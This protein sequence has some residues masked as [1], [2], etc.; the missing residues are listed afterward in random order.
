VTSVAPLKL[1]IGERLTIK[2]SGFLP[3]KSRN[4][5][6]FKATGG[7]AVFAKALSA[8]KTKLVVTVPPKLAPF[9]KVNAGQA[10]ATRFQLRVLAKKLSRSYTSASA[11]PMIAP[12]TDAV[13]ATA[14]TPAPAPAVAAVVPA[15]AATTPPPAPNCDGDS[16]P[17]SVDADDDN[18]LLPDTL[19]RQIGTGVCDA[20][21][22][23]DSMGDGWEYQS[24]SDF[25]R[26]SCPAAGYPTACPGAKPY[27]VKQPYTNPLYADANE[28]Y[29]G[30]YLPAGLE[31][32]MWKAH[33]PNTLT[34]MWYSDGL[35][36]SQD[37]NPNDTCVG[38]EEKAGGHVDRYPV[39]LVAYPTVI[40]EANKTNGTA[41]Y[42]WLYGKAAY[43]LD[44]DQAGPNVGCLSDDERDEDGD[45]LSNAQEV[46]L[47]MTGPAYIAALFNEPLY[48]NVYEGTDP[49]DWDTDGDQIADGMDDQDEDDFWNVEEIRRGTPSSVE[50]QAADG[51]DAGTDPDLVGRDT[52][53]RT[54]LWVDPYNP[55]LPAI[56]ARHCPD[57]VLLGGTP[58][59]PWP[60]GGIAPTRRWPLYH[61]ALYPL[62]APDEI[63]TPA[64]GQSQPLPL[65][66]PNAGTGPEHPLLPRPY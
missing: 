12:A 33:K 51:I 58:W 13:V 65:H 48:K 23:D 37:S 20:D 8:T 59:R 2:G 26:E 42:G 35:E 4:T 55:C 6:V 47:M 14:K 52:T 43:S 45:F 15:T 63:W 57:G 21:S 34:N 46:N 66:Q 32:Q 22:D 16:Q 56:Y 39:G 5:V 27:P 61:T 54:G 31:Y 30:D 44:A 11:S 50:V 7:R 38:L 36:S 1:K 24:A 25:N 18:D 17:D 3:G 19:E 10:Q 53:A 40:D 60:T 29:D 28:D 49:L 64:G 62:D 41:R 9:L